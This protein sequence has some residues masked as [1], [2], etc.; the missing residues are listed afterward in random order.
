MQDTE[1]ENILTILSV[2]KKDAYLYVD[3]MDDPEDD[4]PGIGRVVSAALAEKL[5]IDNEHEHGVGFKLTTAGWR[6]L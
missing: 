2:L 4:L 5:T 6:A 3:R 1:I